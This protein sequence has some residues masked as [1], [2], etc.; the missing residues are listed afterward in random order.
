MPKADVSQVD[1]RQ[2][3]PWQDD[4]FDLVL[5]SLSLHYFA[6]QTTRAIMDEIVRVLAPDGV[7]VGRVN[8]TLDIHHGA[9]QGTVLEPGLYHR[10]DPA[11]PLK[12]FF[13]ESDV[14]RLL[15]EW[16]VLDLRSLEILRYCYPK[17]VVA[18]RARPGS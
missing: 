4:V 14:R 3:L 16:E 5:T 17:H 10:D 1:I 15:D 8:S 12:R 13:T 6:W 9:G 18:F 11:K 7:L 2:G